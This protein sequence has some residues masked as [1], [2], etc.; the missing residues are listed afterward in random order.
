MKFFA[1]IYVFAL[2]TRERSIWKD[3]SQKGKILID[4]CGAKKIA[5]IVEKLASAKI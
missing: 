1:F 2:C 4:G 5:D 3:M